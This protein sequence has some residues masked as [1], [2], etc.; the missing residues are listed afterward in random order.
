VT[1]VSWAQ[2]LAWRLRRQYLEPRTTADA[3]TIVRRLCGVQAQVGSY[4]AQAVLARQRTPAPGA[5]QA[6]LA[7]R[8]LVKTWAMRGTLHL[9][10]PDT[11]G[12]FGRLIASARTWKRP[13][14]ERNFGLSPADMRDLASR[15]VEVLD[16][17]TLTREE[18]IAAVAADA[19]YADRLRS[20]WGTALKPLAWQGLLCHGPSQGNRVTFTS[21]ASWAPDWRDY[22]DVDE[23]AHVAVPAYLGAYGPATPRSFGNWLGR[24]R[25]ARATLQRWFT[26]A[27]DR[28]VKV[29]VE[30]TPAYHLAEHLDELA[31]IK[32][33]RA[34]RLLPPFDQYLLGPGTDDP[35]VLDPARRAE[36]SRTAGWIAPIVVSGGRV[37][38]VWGGGNGEPV[39]V[40]EFQPLPAAALATELRRVR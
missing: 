26:D 21:P 20:G 12:A 32:P 30:G 38:G 1:T 23:A 24:H 18:L 29:D 39:E 5:A 34:V 31:T 14:W 36:V 6:A 13:V 19:P 8:T 3:V 27:G 25:V 16:G 17:R 9:L 37:V 7:S 22:P 10:P 40:T 15:V 35:Q 28:L 2:A 11:A 4:A 33:S